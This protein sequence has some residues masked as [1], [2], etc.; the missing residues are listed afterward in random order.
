MQLATG[1]TVG[2][3]RGPDWLFVQLKCDEHS[4]GE[5]AELAENL[6]ELLQCHM[7]HRMVVE[8]AEVDHVTSALLGQLVLLSKRLHKE[9]GLLRLCGVNEQGEQSIRAARLERLFPCY[10]DRGAAVR[11]ERPRQPR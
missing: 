5:P 3:E 10:G 9:G 1:W 6:W 4:A 2:I 7:G 11:G 8:L